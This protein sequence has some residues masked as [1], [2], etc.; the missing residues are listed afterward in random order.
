[1]EVGDV[2]DEVTSTL[3]IRTSYGISGPCCLTIICTSSHPISIFKATSLSLSTSS[4]IP[5][6][7]ANLTHLTLLIDAKMILDYNALTFG[8][9]DSRNSQLTVDT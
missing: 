7:F 5:L 6:F 8:K 9:F 3:L 1:M 2:W 4:T